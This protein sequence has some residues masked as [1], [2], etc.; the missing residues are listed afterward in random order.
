MAR[1]SLR[2]TYIKKN[3]ELMSTANTRRRLPCLIRA[4]RVGADR[5]IHP[6]ASGRPSGARSPKSPDHGA[7]KIDDLVVT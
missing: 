6:G 1:I 7:P 5:P 4:I 2:H 3:L